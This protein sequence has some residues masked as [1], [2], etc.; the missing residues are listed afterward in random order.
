ME[1]KHNISQEQLEAIER[2]L[3]GQMT[4]D[5]LTAFE[6]RLQEDET[7]KT[8]VDDVKTIFNAI[9]TQALKEKMEDF[10]E[11][12][13]DTP[14]IPLHTKHKSSFKKYLVAAS[15]VALLG[16]GYFTFF[17]K[18]QNE[19]LYVKYFTPDPG[20]PT[21]MGNTDNFDFYDAMVNYKQGDYQ[22]AINKWE[23]LLESNTESDTLNYF[24]G[25]AHLAK[26]NTLLAINYLSKVTYS[27]ANVFDKE[28]HYYLGLAYLKTNETQLA[29]ENLS[30]SSYEQSQ[31]ILAQLND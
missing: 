19:K 26:N 30:F 12:L 20:L 15:V 21:T 29:K 17:G 31:S 10:H 14:I 16:L 5:E 6:T 8:I 7:F 24:I 3:N 28:A 18:S 4:G 2:Y 23:V 1:F 11:E 22:T 25:V 9:E 13:E 27:N